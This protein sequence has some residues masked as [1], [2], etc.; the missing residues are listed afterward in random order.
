MAAGITVERAK[1]GG[2]R[3][4]FEQWASE[5]VSRLRHEETL[6]IDAAL[7]ADGAKFEML[8]ALEHAGPFGA[9]HPQPNFVLPRHVILDVRQVGAGHVRVDLR[10]QTGTRLQAMA[11]RA[12]DND[13]GRF[14]FAKRGQPAHIA[15]HLTSNFWNGARAVQF[16]ICD[17]AEAV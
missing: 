15:G 12:A 17:A 16:R 2:L 3:A 1:L 10:S 11:F 13:L 4:F 14:L 5:E 9:G 7:S 8:D 6:E